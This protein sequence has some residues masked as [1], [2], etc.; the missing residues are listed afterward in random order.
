MVKSRDNLLSITFI[1]GNQHKVKEARGIFDNFGIELEHADLGYPEIQGDL[2]DVARY[3]AKHAAMRLGNP[4]IVEDAGIFIKALEW[5]PGTYS[6]Y[7]QD[8]L[9]NQGI[10]KL[11]T[12]IEDRYAEFR[13]AVGFC[14]PKTE[15]EIFLGTVIGSIG[16]VEKGNSGFAYDPL[17]TSEGYDKTFGELSTNEKNEFS[18]RRRS[19]E[20]FAMW[21]KDYRG[22]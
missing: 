20:K 10:L 14:T 18:H 2:V 5:F 1:T 19:L 13:S 3:G 15:P 22:D 11:M 21:Y 7:V 9:G 16:Y 12:D 4:V 17:F 8:T 6:S